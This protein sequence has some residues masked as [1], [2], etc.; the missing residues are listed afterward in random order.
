VARRGIRSPAKEVAM[1]AKSWMY[2]AIIYV[3]ALSLLFYFSD[4]VGRNQRA[5]RMGTGLLSFVWL[6]Q[7]AF[8]IES[9]IEFRYGAIFSTFGSLFFLSWLMVSLSLLMNYLLRVDFLVFFVNIVG[10]AVVAL[11][12]FSDPSVS[13]FIANWEISDELLFIHI[14]LAIFS[15]VAFLTAAIFSWMYLFLHGQLKRKKWTEAMK[16]L[17][18]LERIETYTYQAVIVG[19]P[20]LI[21][22][23]TLGVV[24]ITLMG[25][26]SLMFDP[27]VLNSLLIIA[28]YTFYLIQRISL[29]ASGNKLAVWNLAAFAF[30]I[31]NY[32]FTNFLSR[33]H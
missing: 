10:F 1:V 25:D 21:L 8:F 6:L 26:I 19:T 20:L 7:T 5:K 24:W 31:F 22:S 33:F 23:L 27:K 3:Y 9:L 14:S 12:F 28:V 32:M 16:R 13:S 2:D 4:F 29:K 18:S 11:N 30:V 15:Y 17:P